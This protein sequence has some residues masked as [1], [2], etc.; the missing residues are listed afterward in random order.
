[1]DA[2]PDPYALLIAH[3]IRTAIQDVCTQAAYNARGTGWA[4]AALKR[5]CGCGYWAESIG[6]QWP[7]DPRIIAAIIVAIRHGETVWP[8]Q[9]WLEK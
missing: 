7:P 2:D 3:V 1:M 9:L 5:E 4:M 8:S 6:I